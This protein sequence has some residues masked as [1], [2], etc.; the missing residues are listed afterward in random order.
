MNWIEVGKKRPQIS[1]RV[2][3]K[4]QL[5]DEFEAIFQETAGFVA[6]IK[7][8]QG[9]Q[10]DIKGGVEAMFWRTLKLGTF[11]VLGR[12]YEEGVKFQIM[13]IELQARNWTEAY[14]MARNLDFVPIVDS[15]KEVE[16]NL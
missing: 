1:E 7:D 16:E 5:G 15:I 8:E 2:I 4:D 12:P 13:E 14:Q 11:I 3:I 9:N 6:L 10:I